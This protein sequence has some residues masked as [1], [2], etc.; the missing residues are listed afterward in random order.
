MQAE[1]ASKRIA[2]ELKHAKNKASVMESSLARVAQKLEYLMDET[3]GKGTLD[4]ALWMDELDRLHKFVKPL[5]PSSYK[6]GSGK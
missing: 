3:E 1:E 4:L 2:V 5:M 6:G